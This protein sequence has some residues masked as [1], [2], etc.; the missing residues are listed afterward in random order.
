MG[1]AGRTTSPVRPA[2][3]TRPNVELYGVTRQKEVIQKLKQGITMIYFGLAICA[4]VIG[5]WALDARAK[6]N[7]LT[8]EE[9]N[10]DIDRMNG[11]LDNLTNEATTREFT[12]K[13]LRTEQPE[14]MET[15]DT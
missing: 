15:K 3:T 12:G 13:Y 5:F 2:T 7:E 10:R 6:S 8:I 14:R 11:K 1:E 9:I 4:L